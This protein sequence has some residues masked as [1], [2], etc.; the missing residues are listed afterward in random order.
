LNEG[1]KYFTSVPKI[2]CCRKVYIRRLTAMRK[3]R[4]QLL[5]KGYRGKNAPLVNEQ[6]QHKEYYE[7]YKLLT[8]P[9]LGSRTGGWGLEVGYKSSNLNESPTPSAPS[10]S[11]LTTENFPNDSTVV[12]STS[13]PS[14]PI[15][16]AV[17]W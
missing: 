17:P 14:S 12:L 10:I 15:L 7:L 4:Y 3:A 1:N 8:I 16:D 2:K 5:F 13:I 11:I 9:R 6:L